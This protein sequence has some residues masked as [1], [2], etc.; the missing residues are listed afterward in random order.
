MI[1][2]PQVSD[3]RQSY[4]MFPPLPDLLVLQHAPRRLPRQTRAVELDAHFLRGG[5]GSTISVE[6]L[7]HRSGVSRAMI[8]RLTHGSFKR[9][10]RL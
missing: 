4:G 8:P 1:G 7:S 6:R 3:G 9:Q 10:P 2:A 5:R